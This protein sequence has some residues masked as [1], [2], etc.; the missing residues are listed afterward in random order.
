M[1]DTTHEIL[2]AAAPDM[3]EALRVLAA[4]LDGWHRLMSPVSSDYAPDFRPS[5]EAV[6]AAA[7]AAANAIA[8]AEGR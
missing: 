7:Y 8:A 2:M 1:P 3:L 4:Q 5:L 6:Q